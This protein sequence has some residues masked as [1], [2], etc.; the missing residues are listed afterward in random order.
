MITSAGIID[1]PVNPAGIV[2][3]PIAPVTDRSG[4]VMNLLPLA[5]AILPFTVAFVSIRHPERVRS[6][7]RENSRSS[8]TPAAWRRH[9]EGVAPAWFAVS[10][11]FLGVAALTAFLT[12]LVR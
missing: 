4:T 5:A 11:V 7:I 9:A 2:R 3:P 10:G 8:R 12:T 6:W 1:T